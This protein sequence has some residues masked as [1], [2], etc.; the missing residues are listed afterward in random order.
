V[1]MYVCM[2]VCRER[3][4]REMN[5]MFLKIPWHAIEETIKKYFKKHFFLCRNQ[6]CQMAYC[7]K[8]Y[9]YLSERIQLFPANFPLSI[10]PTKYWC[11]ATLPTNFPWI[12]VYTT[13]I[14]HCTAYY[15]SLM[16][17]I[18]FCLDLIKVITLAHL[19][20]IST[21]FSKQKYK[22]LIWV[23]FCGCCNGRCWYF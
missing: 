2:Y 10:L 5:L 7:G 1:H 9:D 3:L 13:Y 22:I 6:G 4:T 15:W 8:Y 20:I 17:S 14:Y 16:C 11:H 19:A 21:I 23:N 12:H 18:W